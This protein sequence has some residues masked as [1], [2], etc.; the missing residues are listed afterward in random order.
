[1]KITKKIFSVVMTVM[2]IMSLMLCTQ[3]A[4]FSDV[5]STHSNYTAISTLA[6][7]G[8]INGYTDGTFKPD[9]AVTRA[10]MAKLI[11]VL[12]GYD[13]A[14]VAKSPFTDVPD[15][16]WAVTFISTMKDVGIINGMGDGT[17]LPNNEVTYEQSLKMIVC[18]LNWGEIAAQSSTPED[19]S[20]GY[21]QHATRL[22][23]TKGV[24]VESNSSPAPRGTIAQLLYN[25]LD[26]KRAE[27]VV[28]AN[29]QVSYKESDKAVSEERSIYN[30]NGARII[31]TPALNVDGEFIKDGYIRLKDTSGK[32]YE[33]SV[34]TN[35]A[36]L[37]AAG[38]YVDIK[39]QVDTS[40]NMTVASY[41]LLGT[42]ET[43]DVKKIKDVT[44]AYIEYYINDDYEQTKK[45]TIDNPAVVYNNRVLKNALDFDTELKADITAVVGV[46]EPLN[47]FGTIEV[48]EYSAG[49]LITA[50]VYKTYYMST[51]VDTKNYSVK[52]DGRASAVY[53]PV[54]NRENY[55]IIRK[56]SLTENATSSSISI[57]VD[58]VVSICMSP[59]GKV[60][61][62]NYI[63]YI[64]ITAKKTGSPTDITDN[65]SR[66]TTVV[67]NGEKLII[68][69]DNAKQDFEI[70]TSTTYMVDASGAIV[71]T[72][73]KT[74]GNKKFVLFKSAGRMENDEL[75]VTFSDVDNL[76]S[77]VNVTFENQAHID[78]LS[79][80][81][82]E[83]LWIDINTKK[84]VN[85]IKLAETVDNNDDASLKSLVVHNGGDYVKISGSNYVLG[86]TLKDPSGKKSFDKSNTTVIIRPSASVLSS[87]NVTYSKSSLSDNKEYEDA[88]IYEVAKQDKIIKYI[89][90][91][92]YKG[93]YDT[94]MY[95]VKETPKASSIIGD[96]TYYNLSCYN[97][98]TADSKDL[99]VAK[100][101]VD[102]LALKEGD[103]FTFYNDCDTSGIDID[104]TSNLYILMRAGDLAANKSMAA[105][106]G[107][108]TDIDADNASFAAKRSGFKT[109]GISATNYKPDGTY[110]SASLQLPIY[111][112]NDEKTIYFAKQHGR[113]EIAPENLTT[114]VHGDDDT[115]AGL[116]SAKGYF[117]TQEKSFDTIKS[118]FEPNVTDVKISSSTRVFIY[119]SSSADGSKLTVYKSPSDSGEEKTMTATLGAITT[120]QHLNNADA[121]TFKANLHSASLTYGYFT[122]TQNGSSLGAL[123]IIN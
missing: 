117:G 104:K 103:M 58:S 62:T 110:Y 1:M 10:E 32:N 118:A 7:M 69:N 9:N 85:N 82:N 15:D 71:Y 81:K 42:K 99:K 12:Y 77:E 37:E 116:L 4:S 102:T 96:V 59:S 86:G 120:L 91:N 22:G 84:E 31:S 107:A 108:L 13:V 5:E 97:F 63:E 25:S 64:P 44:D 57:S 8:I 24:S 29:G 45:I 93:L 68:T 40:N 27:K 92:P 16:H 49:D 78:F 38:R 50:K 80:H 100:D 74:S 122:A 39:Y 90:A 112:D 48:S 41:T 123:F 79:A 19:W 3:A 2:M 106:L 17:F 114:Y 105:T 83:L 113:T 87:N 21:R 73:A 111:V 52:F 115:I 51:A 23:I 94:P 66:G 20:L 18:A 33:M 47:Y 65:G 35:S 46:D 119:N 98:R 36:L 89:I 53:I 95:V 75:P 55:E 88:V 54:T 6:D 76:N 70:G 61:G 11:S 14:T 109:F 101:V 30:L 43:I 121:D 26:A 28:D 56:K 67:I 34:G 60:Y 72:T